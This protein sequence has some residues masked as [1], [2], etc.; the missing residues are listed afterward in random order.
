MNMYKQVKAW[1]PVLGIAL[2]LGACSSGGDG[3][4]HPPDISKQP[5]AINSSNEGQVSQT[6]YDGSSGGAT[7]GGSSLGFV[8]IQSNTSSDGQKLSPS[9][10]N[11]VK[12]LLDTAVN[13]TTNQSDTA[14]VSG[15]QFSDSGSCRVEVSPGNF[16]GSGSASVQANIAAGF[17]ADGDPIAITSGDSISMSFNSC[18]FGIG[19]EFNGSVTYI[20]N[21]DAVWADL[22]NDNYDIDA[23]FEFD[24]WSIR[25]TDP[26]FPFSFTTHG[27]VDMSVTVSGTTENFQMSGDSL[28]FVTPDES[29]HLINFDFVA[30]TD[31]FNSTVEANFTI[32]STSL[33]G[34][35][36]VDSY[37]ESTLGEYPTT[38][39]MYITGD[40]SELDVDVNGDGTLTV[41]LTIDGVVQPD[42]PKNNVAWAD[43]GIEVSNAF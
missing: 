11:N 21:S 17:T 7:I 9:I 23:T 2:T 19:S 33:D 37:F 24:N 30:M 39:H 43:L 36:T 13:F 38:G 12:M 27:T 34:Q 14:S 22:K 15:V 18:D 28:Y 3:A 16:I 6:G 5:V 40:N 25:S 31:G 26:D 35:V 4:F 10:F 32:G 20:F 8:G 29:V 42:Y 41:N 1:F